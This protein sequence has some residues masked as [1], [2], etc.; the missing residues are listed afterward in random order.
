MR[1]KRAAA[2]R[3]TQAAPPS[4]SGPSLQFP[5][6]AAVPQ[7]LQ[8]P[9]P[10]YQLFPQHLAPSH[11]AVSASQFQQQTTSNMPAPPSQSGTN[12]WVLD[13]GASFHMTPNSFVLDSC[14]PLS[15]SRPVH[16]ADG[17]V[18]PSSSWYWPSP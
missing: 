12:L 14:R 1:E 18:H 3:G 2:R 16:T 8:Q 17:S 13:S 5:A 7:F 15:Q 10:Q 6:S 4:I 11:S 9:A